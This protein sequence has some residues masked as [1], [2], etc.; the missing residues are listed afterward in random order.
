MISDFDAD[1]HRTARHDR[2]AMSSSS[3]SATGVKRT[4]AANCVIVHVQLRVETL[5]EV[6]DSLTITSRVLMHHMGLKLTIAEVRLK[7]VLWT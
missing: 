5:C 1:L 2:C 4:S 6:V 7:A 3:A